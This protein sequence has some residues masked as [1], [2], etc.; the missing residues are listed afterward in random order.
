MSNNNTPTESIIKLRRE[1]QEKRAETLRRVSLIDDQ[2]KAVN[3]TLELLGIGRFQAAVHD[4]LENIPSLTG[5][6][7][8]EAIA[9]LAKANHNRIK[10]TTAKVALLRAGLIKS[11]KNALSI[12]YGVLQRHEDRF[13]RVAP[14]EYEL[15]DKSQDLPTGGKISQIA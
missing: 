10:A 11:P 2:L 9:V 4:T 1:L 8:P 3:T 6:T 12:V 5:L 7:Q 14:G 15:I 13:R